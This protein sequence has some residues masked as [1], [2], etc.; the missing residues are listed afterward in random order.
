MVSEHDDEG[1]FQTRSRINAIYVH[2]H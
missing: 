2:A 1:G